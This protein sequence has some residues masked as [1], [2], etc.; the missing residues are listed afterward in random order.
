MSRRS[1][2][3]LILLCALV[4]A[5]GLPPLRA[6]ENPD[7]VRA[8][9]LGKII[10][11]ADRW[12]SEPPARISKLTYADIASSPGQSARDLLKGVP[13]VG[14]SSGRKDEAAITIRGFGPRRVALM[15]DGRPVNLPYYGTV[16]VASMSVDKLDE[17][18]IIRGPAS[19]TYGPN[20]MGGVVN[21][22][23]ARGRDRP[24]TRLRASAG[25]NDTGE[26]HLS[27]GS[28]RGPWD[29]FLSARA[30][31]SDGSVLP[32]SFEATGFSG[33]EDGGVRDN[34]DYAEWD[35][36]AKVGFTGPA[37]TDLAL[38]GGYH[39][40]EKGVPA[41]IDEERYWR[42]T[43]WKRYFGDLTLRRDVGPR[44]YLE[45]KAY[46]DVFV[47]TLVDYEDATY[48]PSAV[49]YNST[50]H[51]WDLG[52]IVAL[53][54][55]WTSR[56]HG[57]YGFTLR[58]DQIKKRMNPT[59]PW[60]FH[61]QLTGSVYAEHNFH[62]G[63]CGLADHFMIYNHLRDVRHIPGFSIGLG[64]RL[65]RGWRAFVAAGQSSRFPTL[66]QLW[67]ERSGNRDLKPEV[68][69]RLELGL[70]GRLA[71]RVRAELTLFG[72]RL[73][74]LID[75][76]V[77]RAGRY[78]N[79]RSARTWGMEAVGRVRVCGWL[80]LQAAYTHTRSENRDTG[81]P[82]DQVPRHKVDGRIEATSPDGTTRWVLVVSRVGS[83]FDQE[84]LIGDQMLPAYTAADCR[85]STRLGSRLIFDL[86]IMNLA[87]TYYEE[88]VM[89]PAPGRTVRFAATMDIH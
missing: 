30:A 48:D 79:I 72:N 27:H 17:I 10:V 82:L 78:R 39:T 53:E 29:L 46:G 14:I 34:S 85:V 59:D 3:R 20:V 77:R 35:L 16:N 42:F 84:M 63:S 13:G 41:A 11:T 62:W 49:Y 74:D 47:N 31:G 69:R 21:L 37:G 2:P 64:A 25:S 67:S 56:H 65:A 51:N 6:E 40:L 26:V 36:F 57:T 45:A 52:G 8:H 76:D 61:H 66:S 32:R 68:T 7:S 18:T 1:A 60:L 83:R 71:R 5:A 75:R 12:A 50:H 80:H 73:D 19:V 89:Y 23:T 15:I 4:A 81:D 43:D 87:D 28:V 70:N 58:E 38:S 44:T 88:E 55:D 86:E 22:V 24:G 33:M 9:T 54:H